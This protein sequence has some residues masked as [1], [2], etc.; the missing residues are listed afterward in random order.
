L[1]TRLREN[2]TMENPAIISPRNPPR[3]RVTTI[4]ATIAIPA[5]MNNHFTSAA[6]L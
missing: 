3:E 1:R 5:T 4:A 6:R 2:Q